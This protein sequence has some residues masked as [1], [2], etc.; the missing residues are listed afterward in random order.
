M[1]AR[2]IRNEVWGEGGLVERAEGRREME[3]LLPPGF[4]PERP[5]G[6]PTMAPDWFTVKYSVPHL[7]ASK[8]CGGYAHSEFCDPT[9][10]LPASHQDDG[11]LWR[12]RAI[13]VPIRFTFTR[14]YPVAARSLLPV[15]D[16]GIIVWHPNVDCRP[17]NPALNHG[18]VCVAD[19]WRA[20]ERAFAIVERV[21]DILTFR[22]VA[23]LELPMAGEAEKPVLRPIHPCLVRWA[24]SRKGWFPLE[25]EA[26]KAPDAPTDEIEVL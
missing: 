9:W 13:P 21:A 12:E 26:I 16:G 23:D 20:D 18:W 17:G 5:P 25:G 3:M 22:N 7:R 2:R 14:D 24:R 10:A 4:D 8:P 15:V 19:R 6:N 11:V 1:R